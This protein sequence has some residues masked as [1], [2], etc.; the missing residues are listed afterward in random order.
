MADVNWTTE[1]S[2]DPVQ[3]ATGM[4]TDIIEIDAPMEIG[5]GLPDYYTG[6]TTVIP[7]VVEQILETADKLMRDNITVEEIPYSQ[8]SNPAGGWTVT[9]A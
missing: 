5:V 7:S 4:E 6:A 1:L 2:V 9:I 8:V 3:F